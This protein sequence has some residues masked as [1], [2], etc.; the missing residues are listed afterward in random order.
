MEDGNQTSDKK[1]RMSLFPKSV[2]V[3]ILIKKEFLNETS[4]KHGRILV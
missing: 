3:N 2:F 4:E 1:D